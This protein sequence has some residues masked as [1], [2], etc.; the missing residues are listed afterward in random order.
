M[1]NRILIIGDGLLGE[2]G[3]AAFR[4]SEMLLCAEPNRPMQFS[5]NAPVLLSLPQLLARASSDIIGKKA[6]RI[7]LGLGVDEMKRE[8]GDGNLVSA[9][10]RELV[11][12][13]LK[14]TQSGLFLVTIPKDMLPESDGQVDLLNSA[15]RDFIN[16]DPERVGVFDWEKHVDDF[17][18][19][20][21]ER[22]KFGRS[23]FSEEAKPT[24]LCITLLSMFLEDCILKE[25]N[26]R[27]YHESV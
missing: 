10:Y 17:K 12:E 20:Q 3:E 14:K 7:V 24:S 2:T 19:K 18:E 23:L 15:I 4:C 13:L 6:G 21:E 11:D 16:L 25:L 8:R 9:H 27:S 1:E 22:G 26:K 5:I